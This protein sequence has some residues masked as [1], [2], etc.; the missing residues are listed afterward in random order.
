MV[1]QDSWVFRGSVRYNVAYT[2]EGVTDERI[3]EVL[4]SVGIDSF[5]RKIGGLDAQ[6]EENGALSAGQKQQI[7][8]ARAIIRDSPMVILDEATS[9]V[10]T[11]TEMKIL[12][13]MKSLMGEKT[14]FIIAHRLTTIRSADVILVIRDGNVVEKGTHDS[15]MSQD[16]F[17]AELYRSQFS[18]C[19]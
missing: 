11:R 19:E 5:V 2:A 10:D 9:S 18:N 13:A 16:G 14:A 8:I 3:W 4:E 12:G 1:L 17:Y 6:L 15:L 7:A